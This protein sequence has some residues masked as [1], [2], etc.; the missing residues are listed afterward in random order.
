MDG[1]MDEWSP[2]KVASRGTSRVVALKD[3]TR[4]LSGSEMS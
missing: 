4:L 3:K 2:E 1:R